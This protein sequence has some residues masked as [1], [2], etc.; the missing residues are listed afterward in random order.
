MNVG[1]IGAGFVGL[2]LA[3][4]LGS[5][6]YNTTLMDSNLD[7]INKIEKGIIPF[8]EP[9]LEKLLQKALRQSLNITTDS[10]Y[11]VNNCKIIFVTV[12][13]PTLTDGKSNLNHI[14]KVVGSI[15]LN[16]K[17]TKNTP[18]IVIKSTVVPGT[19]EIIKQTLEKKL[20]KK[21]GVGFG[22]ITNPE[23]L[24]EGSAVND[25]LN[26]HVIVI[27][28]IE[29]KFI[30]IMKKFYQG[31]HKK[32]IP[33]ITTNP[34]TAEMIKY[35]NNSFLATKIS[36]IN[37]LANISQQ[38]PGVN[39]DDV[40]KTIGLDPRIGTPFLKAGPGYGG[41]CLPKDINAFITFS[42]QL[43]YHPTL[44]KMV[45]KTN[46]EQIMNVFS[47]I[48]KILGKIREKRITI[49]GLS[50]KEDS[51][52]IRE[53]V[54]IKLIQLL[55]NAKADIIVHDPLAIKNTKEIFKRKILYAKSIHKSL[56][57]SECVVIMTPWRQY[58]QLSD[59]D[60]QIMKKPIVIDTRR[61]LINK[62]LGVDYYATGV[63]K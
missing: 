63:G 20:G 59:K 15:A 2:T 58:K 36:F 11:I 7:K 14:K 34:Q 50:F 55:L 5:R 49:L 38:L 46:E 17:K 24:S 52:D 18:I 62:N 33:I 56:E 10:K 30:R 21:S 51:D 13:T 54:S 47:Q 26:P 57:K 48:K 9:K 39:I 37:Q 44:L 60:F 16:L 12:G 42:T 1:I 27:G 29:K 45:K 22:L 35:A 53:S 41:S 61:L 3:T 4:V 32:N 8:Y 28:G 43:G 31:F 23:F 19:S 25:T 40:A 6:G